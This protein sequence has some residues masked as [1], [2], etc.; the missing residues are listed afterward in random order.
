M[1]G[2]TSFSLLIL[3]RFRDV[4]AVIAWIE[5]CTTRESHSAVPL[6]MFS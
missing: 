1:S 4:V 6:I 5:L 2:M 3:T